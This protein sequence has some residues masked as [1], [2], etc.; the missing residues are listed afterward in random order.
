MCSSV[1]PS[2]DDYE[3]SFC[4]RMVVA[5]FY[6]AISLRNNEQLAWNDFT[7]APMH[8]CTSGHNLDGLRTNLYS[9]HKCPYLYSI[10]A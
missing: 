2:T 5:I 6:V 7:N 8:T 10:E 1:H 4:V 3:R 9:I